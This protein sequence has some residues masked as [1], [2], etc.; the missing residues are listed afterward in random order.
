MITR[1]ELLLAGLT[2]VMPKPAFADSCS[3]APDIDGAGP[4]FNSPPL[5]LSKLVGK[6]VL[7]E[8]WTFGCYNC[9]NVLPYIKQWY[10]QYA[11]QGL[12]FVGVHTPEFSFEAD[13]KQVKDFLDKN[14][15]RYPVVMDNDYAI[16]NRWSNRYW[17]ALYLIDKTGQVCYRHYGEGRYA[18]TEAAIHRLL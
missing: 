10:G 7:V 3:S 13:P 5:S 15:V 2:A 8:F 18:E 17:P 4:W 11:K 1:R 16:W 12:S 14:D 6:P 9:R